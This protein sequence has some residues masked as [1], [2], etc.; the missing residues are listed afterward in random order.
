VL[1]TLRQRVAAEPG[2]AGVTFVDLLPRTNYRDYRVELDDSATVGV[3]AGEAGAPA[4]Q[5]ALPDVTVAFVD[6][7]YFDVLEAPILAGRGFQPADLAPGARVVIVDQGFVDLV[8]QGSKPDRPAGAVYRCGADHGARRNESAPWYE[9][10]GVVKELGMSGAAE[11]GREAGLYMPASP[12]SGFPPYM[13]IHAQGDPLSL[14]PRVRAIAGAVDPTLRLSEFQRVDQ[15]TSTL[16][17]I[18]GLWLRAT[19]VMTAVALLLS[20]A[21]IYAVLSF[22]VA[23]RTREI[24]VRVAL[25]ASR[26]RL[27]AGIFRRPLTQVGLGVV[28]GAALIALG[29]IA[30]FRTEQ[31]AGEG[32]GLPFGQLALLVAY[33]TLM[34]GVCLLACVVPTRRALGVEPIVAMREE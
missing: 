14:V 2:V 31:F 5:V 1:E 10:V 13:M 17:W 27:V 9:I 12:G 26:R 28:A 6:P 3:P 11:H 30:M 21:G 24:G 22:T 29:A 34:L 33:A 15:V 32:A 25:G 4:A 8:L 16:Q 18:L 7:S 23:R 19:V 20:L